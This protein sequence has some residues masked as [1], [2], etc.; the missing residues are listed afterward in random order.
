MGQVRIK[1]LKRNGELTEIELV[2]PFI[3]HTKTL[4]YGLKDFQSHLLTQIANG[5]FD[6][7]MIG[8]VLFNLSPEQKKAKRKEVRDR[9]NGMKAIVKL[10]QGDKFAYGTIKLLNLS[11]PSDY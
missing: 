9:L 1:D 4:Y 5:A 3:Y 6:Y 2:E 10:T 11:L 7:Q 8:K